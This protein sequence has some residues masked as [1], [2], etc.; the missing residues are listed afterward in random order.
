MVFAFLAIAGDD[1]KE[2]EPSIEL[3]LVT[4]KDDSFT[5]LTFLRKARGPIVATD[6]DGL[7]SLA[8][9]NLSLI[10]NS[11]DILKTKAAKATS[12]GFFG[13]SVATEYWNKEL[14][15]K[16]LTRFPQFQSAILANLDKYVDYTANQKT[17]IT[18]NLKFARPEKVAKLN[19]DLALATEEN[20]FALE[21]LNFFKNKVEKQEELTVN[22][23]RDHLSFLIYNFADT[24][25]YDAL[26]QGGD[27]VSRLEIGALY[28]SRPYSILPNSKPYSRHY[29]EV[30]AA[31]ENRYLEPEAELSG[32][33]EVLGINANVFANISR[34]T[35]LNTAGHEARI[36]ELTEG[37]FTN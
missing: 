29:A 13:D 22:E 3:S 30:I 31:L 6:D 35:E 5:E 36:A 27:I 21:S 26:E 8:A 10:Q 19:A 17:R 11:Q 33:R 24:H 9:I 32:A 2:K 34:P 37:E 23:L 1:S 18:E 14:S 12:E 20:H 7:L 25:A 16:K 4:E 28:G 15:Q